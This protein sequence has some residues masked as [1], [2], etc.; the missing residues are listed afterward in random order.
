M[1]EAKSGTASRG[2]HPHTASLMRATR[3]ASQTPLRGRNLP[4]RARIDRDRGA[5]RA[6][7]SLEA[8]F[9]DVV[10]VAAVQR[11][12]MQRDA[13]IHREGLEP[14]LHQLGV[15]RADLVAPELRL[16]YQE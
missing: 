14:L 9:R 6:R 11:L 15:E 8:R 16:E 5:Q 12:D 2:P 3:S 7:Q 1:S 13:C 10:V 4:G